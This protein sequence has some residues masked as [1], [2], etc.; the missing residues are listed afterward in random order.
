MDGYKHPSSPL[1]L[2][3]EI[4]KEDV[5]NFIEAIDD[6]GVKCAT[7]FLASSGT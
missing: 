1:K 5:K 7:I 2:K 6:L 4:K 3:P